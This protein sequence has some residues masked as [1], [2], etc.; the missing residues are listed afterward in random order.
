MPIYRGKQYAKEVMITNLGKSIRFKDMIV[1][2]YVQNFDKKVL[3]ISHGKRAVPIR[4]IPSF[5]SIWLN[6]LKY[7]K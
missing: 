7:R 1:T 3:S 4:I 6:I 2:D 5:F